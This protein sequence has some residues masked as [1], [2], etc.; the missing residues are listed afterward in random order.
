MDQ[1]WET[2]IEEQKKFA[3]KNELQAK[4]EKENFKRKQTIEDNLQKTTTPAA[5]DQPKE[6]KS[7]IKLR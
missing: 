3:Q 4:K 7:I 1:A 5:V 6:L 2:F